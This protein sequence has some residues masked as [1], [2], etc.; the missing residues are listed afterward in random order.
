MAIPSRQIGWSQTE[1]LLNQI[2]KQLETL[3]KVT[4]AAA[5]SVTVYS[6]VLSFPI[7]YASFGFRCD[8]NSVGN[9]VYTTETVNSISELVGLF[10][11]NA[12]AKTFGVFSAVGTDKLALTTTNTVKNAYCPTG[13]LTLYVF[14]D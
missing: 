3:T 11:A 4:Y 10:N 5:N 14:A 7:S 6:D 2:S 12:E 13:T 9:N 1:I 8:G